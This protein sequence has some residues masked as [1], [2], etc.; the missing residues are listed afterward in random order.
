MRKYILLFVLACCSVAGQAQQPISGVV[1]A[2]GTKEPLAGAVV[3]LLPKGKQTLT[4]AYGVFTLPMAV[5]DTALQVKFVGYRTYTVALGGKG[6]NITLEPESGSLQDVIVSSGYERNSKLRSTGS[7]SI[8]SNELLER[9]VTAGVINALDGMATSVQFEKR[10]VSN[11]FL[12]IRGRST[13]MGNAKPLV[14]L[15][16]FPYEGD[17]D[18]INPNNIESVTI[19]KDAAASAI[20][21]VRASNGVIVITSKKGRYN[22][23][24]KVELNTNYTIGEKPDVFH[25]PWISSSDFIETEK[26]LFANGFY[27]SMEA[28]ASRPVLSP[29]VELLIKKR[30]GLLTA[31]QADAQTNALK[32]Y[33]IRNDVM[34]YL[35]EPMQ[36]QQYAL[37][38]RGGSSK[39]YYAFS[40]GYD[41][42]LSNLGGVYDRI[43]LRA[44][45]GFLLLKGVELSLGI[46]FTQVQNRGGR[47]DFNSNTILTHGTGKNLYPYT[48][49]ADEQ[50]NALA[51]YKDYRN[52]FTESA[53]GKGLLNWTYTPLNDFKEY[54]KTDKQYDIVLNPTIQCQLTKY[55]GAEAQAQYERTTDETRDY[56]SA[57]SYFARNEINRFTQVNSS[58][59]VIGRPVPLGGIMDVGNSTLNSYG[60]RGQL[61]YEQRIKLHQFSVLAGAEQRAATTTGGNYRLYGYDENVLTTIAVNYDSTYRLYHN[62]SST[63]KISNGVSQT[64]LTNRYRSYYASAQYSYADRYFASASAR[65]DGSNIFGVDANQQFVPLWSVGAGWILSKEDFYKSALIPFVKLRLSYGYSGNIDNSLSAYSTVAYSTG[66]LNNIQYGVLQNAPNAD[67]RW[68]R[69]GIMNAGVDF[70]FKKDRITGSVDVWFKKAKDLIG[71]SPLDPTSGVLP[72]SLGNG[73]SFKGNIAD[74]KGKGVDVE[75]QTKNIDRAVKWTTNILFSYADN[76]VTKYYFPSTTTSQYTAGLGV[77]P[78]VGKPVYALY[79]Y[80]WG[81]LDSTGAPMGYVNDKLSK[82]Y[83]QLVVRS[84]PADLVYNG[85]AV[86]PIFGAVRNTVSYKAVSI[87]VNLTY[88]FGYYFRRNS[89]NYSALFNSNAGHGDFAKRWQQKGDEAFT[90]VPGMIYPVN[91]NRETFY[92]NSDALIEKGDHIRIADV[93]LDYRLT[94]QSVKW[95]PTDQLRFY[96]YVQGI[97]FLW[98]ATKSAM[99]PDTQSEIPLQRQVSFGMKLNL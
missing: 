51:I 40:A 56:R 17:L 31:A 23:Q 52:S 5:G 87:S 60:V 4:N 18:N 27:T 12:E 68:E 2:A 93:R 70:N 21:G 15:D 94:K 25:R 71:V 44:N 7:Y 36:R 39:A 91:L 49:L 78:V 82:D 76:R 54:R 55:L 30:D 79:S 85:P 22:Q 98:K 77:N 66:G 90:N 64:S 69:V 47:P 8:V 59:T 46:A 38:I 6:Y 10:P 63:T 65:K 16:G 73:F 26:F 48:R 96:V 88:R 99:D 57:K 81:G 86:A 50:G 92:L 13:I 9:Q 42:T 72:P 19:L 32:Q 1:N 3:A 41:K 62:Q 33:D 37:N 29:V 35:Y 53:V 89:I 28:A 83:T 20:W 95:L 34:Q 24:A 97:G 75:L 58:G 11:G 74:M 67:L 80:R 43:G 45:N 61:R 14:V 84:T